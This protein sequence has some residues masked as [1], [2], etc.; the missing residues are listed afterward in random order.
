MNF[1]AHLYLSGDSSDI[2][3]GNFIADFVKGKSSLQQFDSKIVKGI[4]LHRSIDE[5]TDKHPVVKQSKDRLRATYR[6]YSGVIVDVFYDHYLAKNW[7]NYHDAPLADFAAKAYATIQQQ[8]SIL[9]AAVK[10]MLPYMIRGN[11]LVHYGETEGIHQALT[12]MSRRTPYESHMDEAVV[13]LRK[14]YDEFKNEFE[15]F[16]PEL[17]IH[18]E[19]FLQSRQ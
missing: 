15:V 1:L 14:Y 8:D 18:A 4:E 7:S 2:M 12:G 17:K 9:P 11:W 16:F 5:F 3:I 13:D 10:Q 19:N 6:H